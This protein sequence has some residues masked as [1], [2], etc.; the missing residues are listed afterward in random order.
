VW[1]GYANDAVHILRTK[2]AAEGV[3][4]LALQLATDEHAA[5]RPNSGA[6]R[7]LI[8]IAWNPCCPGGH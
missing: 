6:R 4:E 2:G 7:R 3:A 8:I 5:K 1:V